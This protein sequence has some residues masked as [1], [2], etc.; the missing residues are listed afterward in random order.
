MPSQSRRELI[1]RTLR[2]DGSVT[3]TT[4]KTADQ[5]VLVADSGKLPGVAR[6]CRLD[7]LDV[8][9]TASADPAT[10]LTVGGRSGRG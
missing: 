7:D 8:V 3:D 6:V 4:P 9:T 5:V 1:L 2:A 10:R